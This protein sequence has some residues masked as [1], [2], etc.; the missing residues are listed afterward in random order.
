[1]SF[2]TLKTLRKQL[3]QQLKGEIVQ[4]VPEEDA[5]C[6]FD[7]RKEQCTEGEWATCERRINRAAGELWPASSAAP[8]TREQPNTQA[9]KANPTSEGAAD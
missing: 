9:S 5:T 2:E 1:M 3:W 7:C 6:E 4:D 8:G